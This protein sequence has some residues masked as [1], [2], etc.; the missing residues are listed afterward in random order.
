MVRCHVTVQGLCERE[1]TH[2]FT[3]LKDNVKEFQYFYKLQ[4][5]H[6]TNFY[7]IRPTLLNGHEIKVFF[8]LLFYFVTLYQLRS[9]ALVEQCPR[10]F[11]VDGGVL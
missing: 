5:P 7:N 3:D 11:C 9:W 4:T 2:C 10:I 6:N 8:T 1:V